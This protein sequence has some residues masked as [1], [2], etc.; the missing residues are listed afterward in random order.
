L[1]EVGLLEE[2]VPVAVGDR[3]HDVGLGG[4]TGGH[5][6]KLDFSELNTRERPY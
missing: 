2:D 6:V 3:Y 1:T 4:A 5:E